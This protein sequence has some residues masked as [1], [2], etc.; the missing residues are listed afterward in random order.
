RGAFGLS[1]RALAKGFL[2]GAN[3]PPCPF[4]RRDVSFLR[5]A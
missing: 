1:E 5:H 4:P 3:A 2:D